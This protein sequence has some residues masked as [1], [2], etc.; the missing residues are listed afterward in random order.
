MG[1]RQALIVMDM[2]NGIVSGLKQ[3]DSVIHF[4]K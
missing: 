4:N 3:K 2:Q 1:N